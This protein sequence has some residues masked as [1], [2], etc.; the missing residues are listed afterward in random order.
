MKVLAGFVVTLFVLWGFF[1]ALPS[2][3]IEVSEQNVSGV[4]YNTTNNAFIS[5]NTSFSIRAAAD[6][7]V[8]EKNQSSYC[9]PPNSPYKALV[10]EAAENKDIK[11]SVRTT[12][13]FHFESAPWV[14]AD[15]VIV[16]RVK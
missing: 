7:Y 4:V 11:V 15:N 13:V 14:C 10:N 16:E 8:S 2:L 5:G 3:R 12:K 6:T 9:L 1:W